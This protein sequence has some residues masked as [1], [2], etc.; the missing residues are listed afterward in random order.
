[1]SKE[2]HDIRG[3]YEWRNA[4]D[5][6]KRVYSRRPV[7]S[8]I[9]DGPTPG[10]SW[11][12]I[13]YILRKILEGCPQFFPALFQR[14]E[15]LLRV[16]KTVEGEELIEKAFNNAFDILE[17]EEEFSETISQR[18]EN[19]G[20]LLR[21][22]L[23]AK[24]MEI[25][26]RLF[27]DNAA[28]YDY[29]AFYLLQ[30]PGTDKSSVLNIQQKAL[31]IEPDNDF[32]INNLGWIYLMMGY[33]EEAEEYFRQAINYS[34]ESTAVENLETTEYMKERRLT[35]FQ[36]LLRP[37]DRDHLDDLYKSADFDEVARLCKAYNSDKVEAFKIHHLQKNTLPPHE[38][39]D[40]LY[41]LKEF[42]KMA[43]E[44][45]ARG[46]GVF[47]FENIDHFIEKSG[48]FISQLTREDEIAAQPLP[49]TTLDSLTVF[50]DS[51]QE[52]N[53]IAPDQYT[54]VMGRI[55]LLKVVTR[56]P[57]M[58]GVSW[59]EIDQRLE[60]LIGEDAWNYPVLFKWGEYMLGIGRNP[61]GEKF[62]EKAFNAVFDI[63][64]KEDDRDEEEKYEEEELQEVEFEEEG[65]QEY[66]RKIFIQKAATL[67]ELLRYDLAAKYMEKATRLF[68]DEAIF[69]DLLASYLLHV[70]GS[71]EKRIIKVQ[72][73]AL[74]LEPDN[75]SFLN[76]LGWIFLM[77]G[78][79][80][81]AGE[82]F[83]Q[84]I[85]L[86]YGNTDAVENLK[87]V[88]YMEEHK[89]T[90]LQFLL[91]ADPEPGEIREVSDDEELEELE[92]FE[93]VSKSFEKANADKLRAFAM[94]HL[95][96]KDL[97]PHE[98]LNILKPLETFLEIIYEALED[99]AYFFFENIDLLLE[100]ARRF[101]YQY[102]D[103]TEEEDDRA[104]NMIMRSLTVFY[105]F[106][107]EEKVISQDQYNRVS[108]QLNLIKTDFSGK[109][110]QYYRICDD[111]TIDVEEKEERVNEL[112]GI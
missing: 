3:T 21:Y 45:M 69:Y 77:R 90:Y 73:N 49:D 82:D 29:L 18:T 58:P 1:M 92:E 34:S 41:P 106:L 8:I 9:V 72:L 11:L 85:D 42:L 54:R 37:A 48:Y 61:E 53:V 86:N 87:M 63:F 57:P 46:E 84:A 89:M 39:L 94:Y 30:L 56:M 44:S 17:D 105:D 88:E 2:N 110:E 47:L 112:F 100:K 55:N 93:E 33:Y 7:F 91:H 51:L 31:D 107:T 80:E 83:Q 97:P 108:G 65:D 25:A 75:D 76:N 38:I 78:N 32:F 20:E 19:L 96:K 40:T 71:D 98:I 10:A 66:L 52:T 111:F 67:E 16:G 79:Y 4:Q 35:Y 60:E 74:D 22:D 81:Q 64:V 102:L 62:I 109:L 59:E 50:Y 23:A 5:L 12:A 103:R 26:S 15:Y 99:E 24:Y 27:P 6:F 101:I 13:D 36:Y 14:G 95:Q 43:D 28:F 68:P 70:P 104:L